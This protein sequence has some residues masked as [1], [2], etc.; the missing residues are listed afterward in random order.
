M[1]KTISKPRYS[2]VRFSSTGCAFGFLG[3]SAI[4]GLLAYSPSVSG[5]M[6][7]EGYLW[8]NC[9]AAIAPKKKTE[10]TARA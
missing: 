9:I 10:G 4:G 7:I 5:L 8:I 2:E 6:R 1:T 3:L